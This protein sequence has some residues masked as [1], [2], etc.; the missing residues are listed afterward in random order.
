MGRIIVKYSYL[1]I[2]FI[3][4][5]MKKKSFYN[6]LNDGH[7]DLLYRGLTID[8]NSVVFDVGGYLGTFTD[9][10]QQIVDCNIYIF[11]PVKEYY[12]SIFD[13]QKN[14][15][16]VHCF[17]FGLG[18]DTLNIDLSLQGDG[19]STFIDT[20]NNTN[21]IEN[22]KIEAI[23]TFIGKNK[24]KAINLLKLNIE[25]SEYELL[26][27]LL[28]ENLYINRIEVLLIQF[29]DFVPNAVKR[30][31]DIQAKLS[32]THRKVFEYPFIWEKWVLIQ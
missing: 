12:N 3:F 31:E 11:E 7:K 13:K 5:D 20:S 30:R 16:K 10:I 19:S 27:S 15:P 26:E 4:N 17:N 29:H 14:N 18:S 8:E 9:D 24:I 25:G 28:H 32:E 2:P 22:I 1:Y 21:K 23:N 6:F